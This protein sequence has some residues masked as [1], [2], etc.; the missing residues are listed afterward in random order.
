MKLK[1]LIIIG[2]AIG[3][4]ETALFGL[5]IYL[6]KP[7]PDVSIGIILIVPLTFAANI[8]AGLIFYFFKKRQVAKVIFCNSV[9]GPIIFYFLWNFWFMGWTERNY[10]IYSFRTQQ[11]QFELSLSKTN[12]Y[13]DISDVTNKQNGTTT[14][15]FFGHYKIIGDSIILTDGQ[16]RM[17]LLKSRL[18][19]LPNGEKEIPVSKKI[20]TMN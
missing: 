20:L 10:T 3:L 4:I 15:L 18:I 14:G 11:K 2:L 13:F 16:T 17:Y 9:I 1:G 5:L 6:G 12:N 7:T 19:G 8:I